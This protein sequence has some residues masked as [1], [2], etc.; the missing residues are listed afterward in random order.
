MKFVEVLKFL[1]D[2]QSIRRVNS[3]SLTFLL[4][5]L[6][7]NIAVVAQAQNKASS[8]T[9]SG[10]TQN[11]IKAKIEALEANKE[12]EADDKSQLLALY[13]STQDN[14]AN[15]E[16][17]N[18]KAIE[19]ELAIKQAPEKTKRLQREI[20]QGQQKLNKQ[21]TED[22]TNIS[23]E[24]LEQR[25]IF[26]KGKFSAL[27]E[28][29]KSLEKELVLQNERP[30]LIRQETITAQEALKNGTKKAGSANAK[31]SLQVGSR[32]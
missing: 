8:D 11:L 25:L 27:D 23:D 31:F 21:S 12:V 19:F 5:L 28:Q 13:Q 22:F 24:E 4:I 14:L 18:A 3:L 20:A 2:N 26:E 32:G 7:L 16:S 17:D 10:I 30:L 9:D 15:I 1:M 6:A 29:I